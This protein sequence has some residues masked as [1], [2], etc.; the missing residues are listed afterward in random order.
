[1]LQFAA[2]VTRFSKRIVKQAYTLGSLDVDRILVLECP[3]FD[4]DDESELFD[5][6]R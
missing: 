3:L 1:M 5:V 2:G 4:A 6:L